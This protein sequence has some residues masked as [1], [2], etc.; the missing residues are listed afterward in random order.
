MFRRIVPCLLAGVVLAATAGATF[1]AG[2]EEGSVSL[3]PLSWQYIQGDLAIWTAVVFFCVLV[4]LGKFAWKPIAQGL[5][6]RE[7]GIADQ[8]AQAEAANQQAKDLLAEHEQK[9]AAAGDE[10]RGI[11][12]QGRRDAE[13][14]GREL[15]E[16][17]KAEAKA[18][19]ERAKQQIE[20]AT[21]TAVKEVA[22]RSAQLAVELA[23]KIVHAK[24]NARDHA[25]LIET[26]VA[27][28][29]K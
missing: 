29:V 11:L 10:V 2:H 21:A 13:Q 28:F 24:L 27:G 17:A 5:A 20:A 14:L 3:N 7:Q 23:G 25:Q 26:A 8:I 6:D 9:L 4:V 19:H 12:D 1:A 18:E 22:D 15:L 16:K